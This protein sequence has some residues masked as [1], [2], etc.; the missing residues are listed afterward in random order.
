[1]HSTLDF[2]AV[3]PFF[4]HQPI[5]GRA[6]DFLPGD[7]FDGLERFLAMGADDDPLARRQAVGLHH[8]RRVFAF[9]DELHRFVGRIKDLIIGRGDIG[10]AQ[11]FLA[12][13]LAGFEFG[14]VFLGAEDFQPGLLEGI[15]NARRQGGFR[16]DDRQP[17]LVLLGELD[18]LGKIV[19]RNGDIL[20]V[21]IGAGI[22]RRDKNP[23]RAGTLRDFPSQ[24]VFPP[25]VADD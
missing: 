23:L 1:M 15:D 4:D 3:E 6:E 19:G 17:D 13:D 22:A 14:G 20:A 18:E 8:D 24:G 9:L 10:V 25:A 21:Q 12:K 16:P 7:L 5:A 11:Q 2:L